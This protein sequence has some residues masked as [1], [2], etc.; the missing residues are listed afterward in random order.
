MFS[1]HSKQVFVSTYKSPNQMHCTNG[2]LNPPDTFLASVF[3]IRGLQR[4]IRIVQ[5]L[6]INLIPPPSL[7]HYHL[8]ASK[9]DLTGMMAKLF[10][11]IASLS[12]FTANFVDILF[13]P[14]EMG[15][16]FAV[17]L[18]SCLS[19]NTVSYKRT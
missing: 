6:V 9:K 13:S 11:F 19:V 7:R 12:L 3:Q 1:C 5:M 4:R 14:T 10:F 16:S 8:L 18:F 15:V 2:C 17:L